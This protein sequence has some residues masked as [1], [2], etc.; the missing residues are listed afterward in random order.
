VAGA[1]VYEDSGLSSTIFAH[2][3]GASTSWEVRTEGVAVVSAIRLRPSEG[4][5]DGNFLGGSRGDKSWASRNADCRVSSLGV[6][7]SRGPSSSGVA[8]LLALGSR[9]FNGE[10]CPLSFLTLFA[11]IRCVLLAVLAG[12]RRLDVVAVPVF[13]GNGTLVPG[14]VGRVLGLLGLLALDRAKDSSLQVAQGRL[15]FIGGALL[16][17]FTNISCILLAIFT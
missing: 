11:F 12:A 4:R 3:G 2:F 9:E 7:A 8:D 13:V 14:K 16:A 6:G 17:L 1:A 15:L 5:G 10:R